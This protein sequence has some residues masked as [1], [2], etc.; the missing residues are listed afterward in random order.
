MR[1][2]LQLQNNPMCPQIKD[3]EVAPYFLFTIYLNNIV[4]HQIDRHQIDHSVCKSYF[5][6]YTIKWTYI[7]VGLELPG[8]AWKMYKLKVVIFGRPSPII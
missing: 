3:Q 2:V 4:R 1:K 6:R 7:V 5:S 8:L